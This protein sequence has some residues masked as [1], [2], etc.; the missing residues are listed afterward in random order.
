MEEKKLVSGNGPASNLVLKHTPPNLKQTE[1][2]NISGLGGQ[3]K[4][5]HEL[6]KHNNLGKAFGA[7]L[8]KV[9]QRLWT[10]YLYNISSNEHSDYLETSFLNV[11][12]A[13][14]PPPPPYGTDLLH[15][16]N[17]SSFAL[18]PPEFSSPFIAT[19][20]FWNETFMCKSLGT[21]II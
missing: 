6:D 4:F 13:Y 10:L 14:G 8:F 16:Y 17:L 1:I 19:W 12:F 18:M 3:S 7:W 21:H 15:T 9:N 11:I 20:I 2:I 5:G